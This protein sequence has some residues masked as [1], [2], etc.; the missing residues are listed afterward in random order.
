MLLLRSWSLLLMSLLPQATD[1]R[2]AAQES[3]RSRGFS[4]LFSRMKGS[5]GGSSGGSAGSGIGGIGSDDLGLVPPP[6]P[7]PSTLSF[8]PF[9]A[10]G[11]GGTSASAGGSGASGGVGA[12]E[13]GAGAAGAG[14]DA[15]GKPVTSLRLGD[16]D[17]LL[18]ERLARFV[19]VQES[20]SF[21][22]YLGRD[23]GIGETT[24]TIHLDFQRVERFSA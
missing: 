16:S 14:G 12:A 3:S 24:P 18:V 8:G 11:A 10:G 6:S 20:E 9:D 23:E 13:S 21:K 15:F 1:T 19:T 17:A 22:R 4:R 2:L 7:S 5:T